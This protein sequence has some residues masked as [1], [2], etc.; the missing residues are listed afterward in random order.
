MIILKYEK[1]FVIIGWRNYNYTGHSL[2]G[3][4]RSNDD[5]LLVKLI[6]SPLCNVKKC[7]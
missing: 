3:D 7:I 6:R 5:S 1:N 4:S 2:D